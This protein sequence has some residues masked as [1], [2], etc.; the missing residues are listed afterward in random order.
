MS[1]QQMSLFGEQE[2]NKS[3]SF[4]AASHASLT[5]FVE[6]VKRLMMSAICGENY[7]ESYAK[8]SQDGSWLKMYGGFCQVRMDGSS[9]EYCETWQ[10]WG[11]Y[12]VV[13]LS[14]CRYG[15]FISRRQGCH[16][17]HDR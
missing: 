14:K 2:E 15:N 7:T 17:V 16:R 13:L 10:D 6:N 3:R 9:E 11:G 5:V 4:R 1:Y 12:M 8:L